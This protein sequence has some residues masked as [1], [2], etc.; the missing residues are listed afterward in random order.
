M[1]AFL[2]KARA[3]R[4]RAHRL[5]IARVDGI[6]LGKRVDGEAE[7][8]GVQPQPQKFRVMR[9]GGECTGIECEDLAVFGTRRFE[10][11]GAERDDGGGI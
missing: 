5:G 9:D 3:E 1:A 8:P 6:G 10:W 4:E 11:P 7:S 2:D